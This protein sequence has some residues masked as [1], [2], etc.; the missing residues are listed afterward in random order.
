MSLV[1]KS[2]DI[3]PDTKR[4]LYYKE[5]REMILKRN[6]EYYHFRKSV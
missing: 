1:D 2:E 6:K 4:K 5:H 3:K